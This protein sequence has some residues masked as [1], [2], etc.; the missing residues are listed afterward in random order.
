M[1]G[2]IAKDVA[3]RLADYQVFVSALS[4]RTAPCAHEGSWELKRFRGQSMVAQICL[5]IGCA[6]RC[7]AQARKRVHDEDARMV[8]VVRNITEM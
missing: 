1:V 6:A 8:A 5:D 7:N 2:N 4:G 3:S